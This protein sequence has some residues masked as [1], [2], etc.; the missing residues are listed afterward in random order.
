M[1][2]ALRG[3][4]CL[5]L[6]PLNPKISALILAI[7]TSAPHWCIHPLFPHLSPPCPPSLAP[8]KF[9]CPFP[10]YPRPPQTQRS[11]ITLL[12]VLALHQDMRD[13]L[14]D[15]SVMECMGK[16]SGQ[17][18]RDLWMQ[19]GETGREGKGE[20]H[21]SDHPGDRGNPLPPPS[22]PDP[23]PSSAVTGGASRPHLP[24]PFPFPSSAVAGGHPPPFP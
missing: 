13:K 9:R 12:A 21:S 1:L 19:G 8:L 11:A 14:I 6:K 18:M 3:V 16:G 2:E 5:P 22:Y 24:N 20:G 7:L 10:S 15:V 23:F 17:G 4:L